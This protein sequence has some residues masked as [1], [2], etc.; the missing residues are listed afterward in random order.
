MGGSQ[1][2]YLFSSATQ[3]AYVNSTFFEVENNIE[4]LVSQ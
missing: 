1:Y 4:K 3:M 2:L